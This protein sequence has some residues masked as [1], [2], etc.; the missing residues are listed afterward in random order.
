MIVEAEVTRPTS[1]YYTPAEMTL[2]LVLALALELALMLLLV[3]VGT[4]T[5]LLA[6]A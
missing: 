1:G 2:V 4:G 5:T 6:G 3:V